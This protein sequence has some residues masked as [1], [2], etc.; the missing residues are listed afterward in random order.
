MVNWNSYGLHDFIE[1]SLH[2]CV[3]IVHYTLTIS[4]DSWEQDLVTVKL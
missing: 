1:I 2:L 3:Y 4:V